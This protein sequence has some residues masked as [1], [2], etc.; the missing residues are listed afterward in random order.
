VFADEAQETILASHVVR[1][2]EEDAD[3]VI[4]LFET[5]GTELAAFKGRFLPLRFAHCC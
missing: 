2:L 4:T 1:L 3:I 5:L